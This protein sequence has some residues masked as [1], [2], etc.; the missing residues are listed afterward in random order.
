M[1]EPGRIFC[2]LREPTLRPIRGSRN[3]NTLSCGKM[4][5]IK[6][7]R[8]RNN[9]LSGHKG[10]VLR[11]R[12]SERTVSRRSRAPSRS[13]L[14]KPAV[15]SEEGS[16]PHRREHN[17]SPLPSRRGRARFFQARDHQEDH[18][19][20]PRLGSYISNTQLS[21]LLPFL[22]SQ[23]HFGAI[24]EGGSPRTGLPAEAIVLP[25]A[26]LPSNPSG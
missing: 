2:F 22:F 25:P 12:G 16:L 23:F 20:L 7:S 3:D 13:D 10:S 15:P 19:D 6:T 1:Q 11:T 8:K 26:P 18:P 24:K 9:S 21:L 17:E 4:P 14:G 5:H